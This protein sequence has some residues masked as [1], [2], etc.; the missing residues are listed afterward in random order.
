MIE[1]VKGTISNAAQ[2]TVSFLVVEGPSDIYLI[3]MEKGAC[4]PR[5]T[6]LICMYV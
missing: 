1:D 4:S 6:P 5:L 3:F 2:R